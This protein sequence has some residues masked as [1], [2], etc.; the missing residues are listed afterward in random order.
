[1]AKGTVRNEPMN[2]WVVLGLFIAGFSILG[3][4]IG[5]LTDQ[6]GSWSSI[7]TGVGFI[8]GVLYFVFKK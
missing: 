1:M 4:G 3:S 5:Q 2:R 8:V 6:V 7:G